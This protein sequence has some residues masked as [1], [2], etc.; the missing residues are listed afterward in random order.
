MSGTHQFTFTCDDFATQTQQP[1]HPLSQAISI[2]FSSTTMLMAFNEYSTIV[3]SMYIRIERKCRM[4]KC[5]YT[6]IHISHFNSTPN[7]GKYN[8]L[9]IC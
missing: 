6:H 7:N 5:I 8:R 3:M 9:Y 2:Y 1:T 4:Q